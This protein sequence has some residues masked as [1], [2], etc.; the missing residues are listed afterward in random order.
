LIDFGGSSVTKTTGPVKSIMYTPSYMA[1]EQIKGD[2][3]KYL[4]DIYGFGSTMADIF[5]GI[6][7][8]GGKRLKEF[9][10]F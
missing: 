9:L 7:I 1:P 3:Y 10:E 4:T 8:G 5:F 2:C 6:K